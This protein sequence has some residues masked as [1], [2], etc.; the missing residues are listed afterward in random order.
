MKKHS[1]RPSG[2]I[3]PTRLNTWDK[4]LH[5]CNRLYYRY[6]DPK[7]FRSLQ[8]LRKRET[9]SGYSLKPFDRHKCIFVRIPKCATRSVS[10]SLFGNLAG[11]HRTVKDYQIVFSAREFEDYFKF[12]IVRNPWDRLVSAFFF[13]KKGGVDEEDLEFSKRYLSKYPDFDSF[14]E[15]GL[16]DDDIINWIHFVPQYKFVCLRDNM[17]ATDF[18][19]RVESLDRD[20]AT[21]ANKLGIEAA[22]SKIN[23]TRSR[24]KDFRSYY[25][26]RTVEIVSEIYR[27]DIELFGYRFDGDHD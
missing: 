25:T 16:L 1:V 19:G 5:D 13:L 22:L 8:R 2:R 27:D 12:T 21:I 14:V 26:K 3:R 17:L 18:V 10:M 9:T 23:V 6:R 4:L 7:E 15:K 24:K 20:F 11:S